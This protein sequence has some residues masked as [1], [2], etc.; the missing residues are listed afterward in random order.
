VFPGIGLGAIACRARTLP[1][2]IFLVAAKTLAS[3]VKPEHLDEGALY[4]PLKDIRKISLA[5]AVNV[6]KTAHEK[7][8][9]RTALPKNL[10]AAIA[11]TMYSP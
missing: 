6:A 4:P 2:E 5:I 11:A 1:D 3:L 8:L 10:R 9:A 7:G